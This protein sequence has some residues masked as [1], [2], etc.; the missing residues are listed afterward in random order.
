MIDCSILKLTLCLLNDIRY[1]AVLPETIRSGGDSLVSPPGHVPFD[2][3][4]LGPSLK[5]LGYGPFLS[6]SSGILGY[7]WRL[8]VTVL[9]FRCPLKMPS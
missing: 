3:A 9:T 7:H 5:Q 2:A 6:S 1:D 8:L 4:L